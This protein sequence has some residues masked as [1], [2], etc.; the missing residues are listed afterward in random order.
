LTTSQR[1]KGSERVTMFNIANVVGLFNELVK[2]KY[3]DCKED[4]PS[5]QD[6]AAADQLISVLQLLTISSEMIDGDITLEI[7]EYDDADESYTVESDSTEE[8]C[9]VGNRSYSY[10]TM[11]EIVQ[12][13]NSHQFSSVKRRYRL[14]K[15]KKH[16]RRIRKYVR[17]EGTRRQKLERL[18]QSV[19]NEFKEARI[20]C[21]PVHDRDL[22]RLAIRKA[23]DMKLTNFVASSFWVLNFKRRHHITSRKVTKFVTKNYVDDR[24]K[25]IKEEKIFLQK[26]EEIIPQFK[27]AHV[28]NADQ[29]SFGY[30][31]PSTRT[32]SIIG[33]KIT[34][35]RVTSQNAVTHSHT[36]MPIL[37]MGGKLVGPVFICLQEPSG[38]LGPRVLQTM[39][40]AQNIHV[41]CSKSGKL[42]KSHIKYWAKEVLRPSVQGNCLLLLDSWSGQTDPAN[43]EEAF[44]EKIQCQLLQ[45]PPKTTGDIQPCDKYFFRQWKYFYQRCFDHVAIDQINIDLRLR[46][47][48]LKLH[49]L[50]HNQLSSDHFHS[51]MEYAWYSCG[52]TKQKPRKFQSVRDICFSFSADECSIPDCDVGSFMTCSW[53]DEVLC[54]HHFFVS[55][56]KHI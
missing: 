16:L 9:V 2:Q 43:I 10:E 56:H 47:N 33:E 29:S 7:D 53:C 40:K 49:S 45:I 35:G 27:T 15:D 41:T 28:L 8:H 4:K 46:D 51:M 12:F 31:M 37:S 19:F 17:Q 24:E 20:K 6:H 13:A 36:I 26:A 23:R 22:Q 11:C 34:L 50:I 18:D 30:E 52:Y 5:S 54:F 32:L 55:D 25:V 42:T 39:Y 48:I 3:P 44:D 1:Y 14:I 21:L 38:K